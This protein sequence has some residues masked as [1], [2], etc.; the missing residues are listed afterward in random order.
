[1]PQ[2]FDRTLVIAMLVALA[3]AVVFLQT[4]WIRA[5]VA[6]VP[7]LL[8]GTRAL[9]NSRRAK[10][11]AELARE[12]REDITVRAHVQELLDVLREFYN[13]AHMVAVGQ[14]EASK[15]KAKALVVEDKL[16]RMMAHLLERVDDQNDPNDP[17][18]PPVE[19][20]KR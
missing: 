9:R 3:G 19:R 1:V 6:A 13:T 4:M 5:A 10:T 12:R 18:D 2:R 7:I 17:S 11:A 15:A 14:L 20:G 8:L 16:N